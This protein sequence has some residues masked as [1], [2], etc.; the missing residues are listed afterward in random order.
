MLILFS[1]S[2]WNHA[3]PELNYLP[4][5]IKQQTHTRGIKASRDT[6]GRTFTKPRYIV[7]ASRTIQANAARKK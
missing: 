1:I 3:N 2:N 6:L 4:Q 5:Q 7:Y